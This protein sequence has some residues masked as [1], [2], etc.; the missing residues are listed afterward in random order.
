[1]RVIAELVAER[2][3]RAADDDA[4]LALAG[5]VIGVSIAA[6]FASDGEDRTA[7]FLE[8]MDTGMALLS[9]AS[10]SERL[11]RKARQWPPTRMVGARGLEPTHRRHL[12]LIPVANI[13][14]YVGRVPKTA[15]RAFL[16]SARR[17]TRRDS[18]GASQSQVIR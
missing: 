2:T 16:P 9:P 15:L 3:G 14:S 11:Q 1:V 10:G 4:V 6:W 8:R 12:L 17:L 13:P 18:I 5:A 7:R